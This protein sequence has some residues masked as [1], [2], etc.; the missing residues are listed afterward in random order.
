MVQQIFPLLVEK[1][2]QYAYHLFEIKF[3]NQAPSLKQEVSL[4]LLSTTKD[5]TDTNKST[6]NRFILK[7]HF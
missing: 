4:P 2:S 6:V 5:K 3:S 7:R 1:E